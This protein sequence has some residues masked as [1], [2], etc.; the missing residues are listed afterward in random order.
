[1]SPGNNNKIIRVGVHHQLYRCTDRG[2]NVTQLE[3]KIVC[4]PRQNNL[5]S[6]QTHKYYNIIFTCAV[7]QVKC[8]P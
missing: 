6:C 3:P 5:N 8:E 1:M 4:V 7:H 2:E